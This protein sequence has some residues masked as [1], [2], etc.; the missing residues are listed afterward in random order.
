MNLKHIP[1][2]SILPTISPSL[3]LVMVVVS[4]LPA[5]YCIWKWPNNAKALISSVV[6][7]S[8]S[9]FMFGYHVHEKA[10]L[11]PLLPLILLINTSNNTDGDNNNKNNENNNNNNNNKGH[12]VY[13]FVYANVSSWFVWFD[14]IIHRKC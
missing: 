8:F 9:T 14:S 1:N 7:T 2:I 13:L 12:I 4:I 10:I 5:L 6:Y 11:V 3:S